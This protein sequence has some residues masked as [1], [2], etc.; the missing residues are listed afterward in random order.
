MNNIHNKVDFRDLGGGI[1]EN[2]VKEGVSIEYND[3]LQI[4]EINQ[5]IAKGKKYALLISSEPFATIS[6]AAR[7]L[8]ASQKFAETT[9]AK[10]ILVDSLGQTLVVNFYL[11]INKPKIKTKMFPVKD[12]VKAIEW[13]KGILEK[14]K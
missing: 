12:K 4:K 8:S 5:S 2:V 7:E 1:I 11:S 14:H 3:I 9:L 10:A 6:K 13:L